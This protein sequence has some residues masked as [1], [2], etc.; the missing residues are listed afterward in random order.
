MIAVV[1]YVVLVVVTAGLPFAHWHYMPWRRPLRLAARTLRHRP[2]TDPLTTAP[3]Q[4]CATR[5]SR[6]S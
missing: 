3:A 4:P 1:A 6:A 5:Y 2:R